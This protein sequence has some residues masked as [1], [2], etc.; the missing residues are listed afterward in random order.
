V[1]A[2]VPHIL[3]S[4]IR[5]PFTDAVVNLLCK[6][7]KGLVFILCVAAFIRILAF[8]VVSC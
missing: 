3:L 7:K 5:E 1:L 6:K 4:F 8:N 2:V